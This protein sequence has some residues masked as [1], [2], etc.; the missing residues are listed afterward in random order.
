VLQVSSA[1]AVS[2]TAEAGDSVKF[3]AFRN[4]PLDTAANVT[5]PSMHKSASKYVCYYCVISVAFTVCSYNCKSF[6]DG[7]H[8]TQNNEA[9]WHSAVRCCSVNKRCFVVCA[10]KIRQKIRII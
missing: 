3:S 4:Q 6:I 10:W 7:L 5:T 2:E 9:K 1:Q 8:T